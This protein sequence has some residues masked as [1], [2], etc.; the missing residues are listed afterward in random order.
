MYAKELATL[1]VMSDGR[2]DWGIGAGWLRSEYERVGITFDDGAER[3]ERLFEAVAVMK[4]CFADEPFTFDGAH[5]RISQLDGRP[6]P[7]QRPH[8]RLLVAGSARRVLSFAGEQADIVGV[9]PSLLSRSIGRTP[10][11]CSVEAAIDRQVEWI[12]AAAAKRQPTPTLNMVAFPGHRHERPPGQGP[13]GRAGSRVRAG[14]RAPLAAHVDRNG[15]ADLRI[16]RAMARTLGGVVLGRPGAG[17]ARRH[18]G[19]RSPRGS[20]NRTGGAPLLITLTGSEGRREGGTMT[21]DKNH[22]AV[23]V[24]VVTYDMARELPRTLQSLASRL[25]A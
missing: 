10:P 16:A 24:V 20:L 6:K 8:P 14:R 22:P 21:R 7:V 17:V 18:A 13:A 3:A 2:I 1:D 19:D 23:S 15:R 9:A 11:R 25:P 5:Y 4:R 12:A